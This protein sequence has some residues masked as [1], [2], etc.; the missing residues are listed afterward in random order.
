M[1]T[2]TQGEQHVQTE[3]EIGVKQV[4]GKP[5]GVRREDGGRFSPIALERNLPY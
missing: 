2:S 4:T 3:A 5:P 1:D